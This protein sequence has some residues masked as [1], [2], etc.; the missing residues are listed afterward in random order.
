MAKSLHGGGSSGEAA[1]L[2]MVTAVMIEARICE[3]S[4]EI[5]QHW[6]ASAHCLAAMLARQCDDGVLMAAALIGNGGRGVDD[7]GGDGRDGGDSTHGD[8]VAMAVFVVVALAM[9]M[10][11]VAVAAVLVVVVAA[12]AAAV[13]LVPMVMIPVVHN[14]I[15][16]QTSDGQ[17][18]KTIF[19]PT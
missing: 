10:V 18:I 9:T 19:S 14:N 4:A 15:L 1:A 11:A 5:G 6:S 7:S 8:V 3:C 13:G 12:A 2:S 16:S 17:K